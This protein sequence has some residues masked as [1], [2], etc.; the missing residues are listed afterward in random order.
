MQ[1]RPCFQKR[2]E[3]QTVRLTVWNNAGSEMQQVSNVSTSIKGV[4]LNVRS[5]PSRQTGQHLTLHNPW[6]ESL[7]AESA[8]VHKCGVVK[9][10]RVQIGNK[11]EAC[12]SGAADQGRAG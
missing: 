11:A 12:E 8:L 3:I 1:V 2:Y 6:G 4:V 5:L 7:A 9:A 10:Q